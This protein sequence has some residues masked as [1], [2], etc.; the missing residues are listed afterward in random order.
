MALTADLLRGHTETIILS[1]LRNGASYGYQINK[2][3]SEKCGSAFELK[4]A[5]L[6]TA[7]R[8][9]E[10]D[11]MIRSWWGDEDSGARRRY[12]ELTPLGEA[13]L[14]EELAGWDETKKLID[15]LLGLD[16]APTADQ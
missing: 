10:A 9:L 7:F 5:T 15:Q 4:E 11:G 2:S 1:H 14:R 6:Y 16:T 13:R 12:Y 8:R 3:I